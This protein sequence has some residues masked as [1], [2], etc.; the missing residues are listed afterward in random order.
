VRILREC[1]V[2]NVSSFQWDFRADAYILVQF[3]ESEGDVVFYKNS[4]GKAACKPVYP[5][6]GSSDSGIAIPRDVE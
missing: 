3:V 1:R 5:D 2:R 6:I 4:Y